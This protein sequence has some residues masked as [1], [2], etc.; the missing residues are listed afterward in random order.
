[1]KS[2]KI[3]TQKN[4]SAI[5]ALA[6]GLVTL[7]Q[8]SFVNSN[9]PNDTTISKQE[10]ALLAEVEMMLTE[11]EDLA[12]LEE[13]YQEVENLEIELVK[14]FDENDE[15]VA[16]GIP[17]EDEDL[18]ALVNKANFIASDAKSKYFRIG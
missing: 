8:A 4:I 3:N 18:R 1:M 10:S 12:I 9:E 16:E 13:A 2:P 14:V 5:I 11:D 17:S 6:L 7:F 15:L